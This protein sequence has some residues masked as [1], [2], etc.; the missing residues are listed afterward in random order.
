[1]ESEKLL[2]AKEWLS[3]AVDDLGVAEHLFKT[4]YP[5]P[6]T[7]IGFH[8]QQAAEKAV[9]SLIVLYGTQGGMP[10]KH[11]IFLLLNQIKNVTDINPTFYDY[12]DILTPYGIALR[13]PNEL[14][15]TEYHAKQAIEM[16][17]EFVNWARNTMESIH[18]S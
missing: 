17:A 1:M 9:K 10:K 16:A 8:S 2:D 18:T 11:D 12:A 6:L 13:Y 7:I 14:T 3:Y 4:Y 15:L 5:K